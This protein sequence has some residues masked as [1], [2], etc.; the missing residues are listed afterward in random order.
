MRKGGSGSSCRYERAIEGNQ[1][2]G[3]VRQRHETVFGHPNSVISAAPTNLP[4]CN[5]Y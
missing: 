2:E 5:S 4:F 1:V 3:E